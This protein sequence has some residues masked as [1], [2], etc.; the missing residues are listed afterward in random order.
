MPPLKWERIVPRDTGRGG[1]VD[2]VLSDGASPVALL[3]NG[4]FGE[5]GFPYGLHSPIL[6]NGTSATIQGDVNICS[7]SVGPGGIALINNTAVNMNDYNGNASYFR[8][9][10]NAYFNTANLNW[11]LFKNPA[12][13]KIPTTQD[14][15]G[16]WPE[17]VHAK[18]AGVPSV[19]G[20][21]IRMVSNA[22]SNPHGW[23]GGTPTPPA[24]V[25]SDSIIVTWSV[26]GYPR[27]QA[28]VFAVT[29]NSMSVPIQAAGLE[30][31][32]GAFVLYRSG[33]NW[34]LTRVLNNPSNGTPANT[35]YVDPAPQISFG[36]TVYD[37]YP[38]WGQFDAGLG[39]NSTEDVHAG[40]GGTGAYFGSQCCEVFQNR[41]LCANVLFHPKYAVA[42]DKTPYTRKGN[43]LI[44]TILQ[45][46]KPS[47][48][49][50]TTNSDGLTHLQ[51]PWSVEVGNYI[52]VEGVGDIYG[53]ANIGDNQLF[54]MGNEGC[55]R[56]TG[57]LT[58]V[59]PDIDASTFDVRPVIGA[60]PIAHPNAYVVT[61]KGVFYIGI[62]S[63]YLYDGNT[64]EDVLR[65]SIKQYFVT[66]F[67]SG[68]NPT[69][70]WA[71]V[72]ND[73]YVYFSGRTAGVVSGAMPSKDGGFILNIQT[74]KWSIFGR[75]ISGEYE[76]PQSTVVPN[77]FWTYGSVAA[78][79][80]KG[81]GFL[82]E[83]TANYTHPINQSFIAAPKF[84][85]HLPSG[86][87]NDMT[88]TES[89]KAGTLGKYLLALRPVGVPGI[90]KR[91][92]HVNVNYSYVND[93][94]SQLCNVRAIFGVDYGW[95]TKATTGGVLLGTLPAVAGLAYRGEQGPNQTARFHLSE[96]TMQNPD[97]D[98]VVA[99]GWADALMILF[100]IDFVSSYY[101]RVY[102]VD[103]SYIERPMGKGVMVA[104]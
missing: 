46:E 61:R 103:I 29:A 22:A 4:Y 64:T 41:I 78:A 98:A 87:R 17:S 80:Q 75:F 54:I 55:A 56:L 45:D 83:I 7:I 84:R 51:F 100:E 76:I 88:L 37:V 53:M 63:I 33:T 72:L 48:G 71:G 52:D 18:Y 96:T 67:Q 15:S 6:R 89:G 73:D 5:D 47:R 21:N 13:T 10:P 81:F 28:G 2:Q 82:D 79:V 8:Y 26:D 20:Y 99:V 94:A 57:Y 40:T 101:F 62:D 34:F 38:N 23:Q 14:G 1:S 102:S 74:G 36:A 49:A 59:V 104:A 91:F 32:I 3:S 42:A 90:A 86:G 65:G 25:L 39:M 31:P 24:V 50:F 19:V 85:V 92:L 16:M 9:I 44:Y 77:K 12:G 11:A 66:P 60:P 70:C 30:P 58:T 68:V 93:N 27:T 69:G 95:P 35:I 97:Q 43:R